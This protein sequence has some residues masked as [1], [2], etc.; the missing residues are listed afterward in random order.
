MLHI[1][2]YIDSFTL[3]IPVI[4]IEKFD[5][6]IVGRIIT[7]YTDTGEIKEE[8]KNNQLYIEDRGIK[9]RYSYRNIFKTS[10]VFITITAKMLQKDYFRG[11]TNETIQQLYNYVISQGI[12]KVKYGDFLRAKV[13]DIDFATNFSASHLDFSQMCTSR[14]AVVKTSKLFYD[15]SRRVTG[16][17]YGHREKATPRYPFVKFYTK[18][19]ELI[20]N[21]REFYQRFLPAWSNPLYRRI[22]VTLKNSRHQDLLI[23]AKVLDKKIEDLMELLTIPEETIKKIILFSLEQYESDHDIPAKIKKT[24]NRE[25]NAP[26]FGIMMMIKMMLD[27][28]IPI[29][30]IEAAIDTYPASTTVLASM[31]S[32]WKNK[33]RDLAKRIQ[34]RKEIIPGKLYK[35]F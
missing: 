21:S 10:F 26:D 33:I 18:L 35:Y 22:E 11:I 31:R 23:K 25:M 6:R 30:E 3:A 13:F 34:D 16:L 17:Q 24:T 8:A 32:R 2:R 20:N 5:Y 4:L 27:A 1:S 19:P 29:R 12:I 15:K 7:Y 9:T 28:G 14:R